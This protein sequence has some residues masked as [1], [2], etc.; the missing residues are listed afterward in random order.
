MTVEFVKDKET[1]N[2]YRYTATGDVAGSIY[3]RKDN[4][5]AKGDVIVVS[6][7]KRK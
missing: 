7:T 3:V 2:T 1:K 5:L 6:V 4:E